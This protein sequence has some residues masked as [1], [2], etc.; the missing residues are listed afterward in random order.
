MVFT[1][2][3]FCCLTMV[4][5]SRRLVRR[6]EETPGGMS[7]AIS[8][9]ASSEMT[10]GPLGI[11]ET[12]PRAD[13]PSRIAAHACCLSAMQQILTRGTILHPSILRARSQIIFDGY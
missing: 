4:E 1:P 12:N 6:K 8:R 3:L 9:M 5:T 2:V 10:P 11:S 7:F 13:A